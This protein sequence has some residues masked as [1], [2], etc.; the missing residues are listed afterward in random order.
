M[1]EIPQL[2]FLGAGKLAT[3][4]ARGWIAAGF[5]SADRIVGAD[6]LP[7]AREAFAS[8]ISAKTSAD[9]RQTVR[10]CEL[11]ILSVK[12]QML[13]PVLAEIKSELT[14]KQLVVSVVG[15]ATLAQLTVGLGPKIRVVRVLPN[16]ASL[17]GAGATAISPGESATAEDTQL[18]ER[19]FAAVG[20]VHRLPEKLL[21]AVTGLSGSGPAY[22][23]LV[24]EALSDGGVRVGLPRDVATAL[25][26]QTVLGT[27]KMVLEASLSPLTIKEMV[28]SPGGTTIAGLHAMERG[29]VRAALMD[30]VV[31]ASIRAEELGKEAGKMK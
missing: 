16:T 18:V 29:G 25:A 30:A 15:G 14:A 13:A 4:L 27:A 26:A 31:A 17:V 6:P 7:K 19:M 24:I 10:D 5:T 21:D 22:V 28:A 20:V 11:L 8:A 2:G 1:A 3:A 12:P 23:A 9:N